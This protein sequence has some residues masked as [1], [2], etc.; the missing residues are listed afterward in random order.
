MALVRPSHD[1]SLMKAQT[2]QFLQTLIFPQP[3]GAAI[4]TALPHLGF[5]G[6]LSEEE[7]H[8]VRGSSTYTNVNILMEPAFSQGGGGAL[9]AAL[10]GFGKGWI[11]FA[12]CSSGASLW[13]IPLPQT[14]MEGFAL[15]PAAPQPTGIRDRRER[16]AGQGCCRPRSFSSAQDPPSS[17]L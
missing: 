6:S 14:G 17:K 9:S 7:G 16:A 8:C 11:C 12:A 10:H 1:L 4:S 13:P 15:S 5:P 2:S 3:R